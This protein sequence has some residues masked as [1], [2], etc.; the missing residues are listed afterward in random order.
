MSL[1]I[2]I[3]NTKT[4][5]KRYADPDRFP[6]PAHLFLFTSIFTSKGRSCFLFGSVLP[7]DFRLFHLSMGMRSLSFS[8][9][10][11][12]GAKRG[13]FTP[14]RYAVERHLLRSMGSTMKGTWVILLLC[15]KWKI[16]LTSSLQTHQFPENPPPVL[17][18][19]KV[20]KI[21]I[22]SPSV[23]ILLDTDPIEFA[24]QVIPLLH[25]PFHRIPLPLILSHLS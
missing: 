25:L 16:D 3:K 5:C 20:K 17:R 6:I 21:T 13:N 2:F 14:R 4:S 24:R 15:Q 12:R 1:R 23:C 18:G 9:I 8:W 11:I 19:R 7:H 10:N 22:L